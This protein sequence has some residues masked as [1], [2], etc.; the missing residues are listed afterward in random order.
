MKNNI[1]ATVTT[2]AISLG[3]TGT[4]GAAVIDF[5]TKPNGSTPTDNPNLNFN[6]KYNV[7]GT[8]VQFGFDTDGDLVFDLRAKFENRNDAKD[9]GRAYTSKG[10]ADVDRT[11][12]GAGGDWLLRRR[13]NA[14]SLFDGNSSSGNSFLVKYSGKAVNSASGQIWDVDHAEKYEINALDSSGMVIKS[15][16]TP[17]VPSNGGKNTFDGKPFTFSF[18]NLESSIGYIQ[19]Q[20]ISKDGG[21]GFAFDNFNPTQAV[22]E[23]IT[24][25]VVAAGMGGAAL[26]RAK[27][28]KN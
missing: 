28:K 25:L 14:S 21:G 19:I 24:G 18:A 15:I 4:A 22:P 16:I 5:E 8:K 27:S 23:P 11:G 10:E 3:A 2:V 20:G 7:D 12:T 26:R 6:S 1:L 13:N 17:N 9:E